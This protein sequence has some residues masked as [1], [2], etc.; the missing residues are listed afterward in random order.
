VLT[1]EC[2]AGRP[3]HVVRKGI[4][5]QSKSEQADAALAEG[6]PFVIMFACTHSEMPIDEE[7]V[8]GAMFGDLQIV[9]PI[10]DDAGTRPT[11]LAFG[12]RRRLSPERNNRYSA[13]AVVRT[14]NPGLAAIEREAVH[15]LRK[16]MLPSALKY[17]I[18][19]RRSE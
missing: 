15:R 16:G 6:M 7:N 1:V 11:Y 14:F 5:K 13:V 17:S 10:D 19:S 2:K 18:W 8:P 9:A 4:D 12:G 3:Y